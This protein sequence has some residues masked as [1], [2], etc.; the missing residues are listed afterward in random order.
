MEREAAAGNVLVI[1]KGVPHVWENAGEDDLRMVIEFRPALNS[2]GF[3]ESYFG[4]GQDGK[5]NPKTG[6]PN[7]LRMALLLREFEPEIYLARPPLFVQRVVF[8]TL[9]RI[10]KLLGYRA[11]HP[12]PYAE[13]RET[14]AAG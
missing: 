6:L 5:T 11:R 1:P 8:G 3:F 12:Y 14:L 9:A 13:R 7:L 4:L 10:G 2:E